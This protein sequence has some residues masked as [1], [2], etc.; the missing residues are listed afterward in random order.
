MACALLRGGARVE[1]VCLKRSTAVHEA[2][3]VGCS[4]IMEL[5]LQ[6]GGMVTERDQDGVT[7]M[8]IAA[9]YA[10]ADVVEVL[11]Y[12]GGDVNARAPNGD[13]VLF[14]A[15]G[16][17]NTHCIDLLL[18]H[19]ANPNV[20]SLSSWLPIHR[21]AY[22][23]HYL[24]LDMLIPI[25][26]R[27]AIRLSGQSPV[28][29]AADGGRE[30]CLQ[31]LVERGFDVNSLLDVHISGS[32]G[33]MRRSALFF[34]VSNGDVP[35]TQTLLNS[36][37]LPD[38]D[39]LRCLLVAVRAGRYDI[40]EMLLAR[41]ADVNCYFTVVSDTVFP[42]ALQYCLRDEAMMRLLL[43]NGYDADTCF[44]C[45][46]DDTWGD[47]SDRGDCNSQEKVSFC[48]FLGVSWL[49]QLAGRAVWI[50]LDYVGHA[51]LCL[52]LRQILQKHREWTQICYLLANPRSLTHLCR[53][54]IR[55][56]IT[57]KRSIMSIFGYRNELSKYES[58]DEDEL[59]AG[60]SF[61]EIQELERELADIDPD[62]N[63]PIGLRQ[64]DQ[65]AKTPTDTFSREALLKYCKEERRN[66]QEDDRSESSTKQ[67]RK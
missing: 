4:N 36:G 18:R 41:Q 54:A 49:V 23:G 22:E 35:C 14:D 31:L 32:Y 46:H 45:N 1:Q 13:S 19:G 48:D 65:T 62:D 51:P 39:P 26:T 60:L 52:K 59:L 50:L 16:A 8:A 56:E 63:I 40:V 6:H 66:L 43:A 17:G 53:L 61:E 25:T 57:P 67:V 38:L 24:A 28:H 64:K 55:K 37:A 15:A 5:L 11:I 58:L 30:Q 12:N 3:K 9:E 33:D 29:S 21:A 7:P 42:T 44:R 34:A 20:A 27:R 47:L 2:A 10:H